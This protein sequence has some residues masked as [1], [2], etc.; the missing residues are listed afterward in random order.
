M[1][2]SSDAGDIA[3]QQ[4]QA[5]NERRDAIRNTTDRVN[6]IYD[7]PGR[8][9]QYASFLD[10]MRQ[11]YGDQ[12]KKQQGTATR[13]LKFSTARGGLSG[14]SQDADSKRTLGEE[15]SQGVIDAENRSQAALGDLKSQDE[16]SRLNLIQLAQQGLGATDA[17]SRAGAAIQANAASARDGAT[18]KGLGDV[19]GATADTYKKQQD[20]AVRRAQLYTPVGSPYGGAPGFGG[21]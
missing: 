8:Q 9:N 19:F 3:H 6:R 7:A 16:A 14:G 13:Q 15:F 17:A 12:L 4:M 20:A 11:Q 21:R 2:A 1:G 10:A 18:A 5:D